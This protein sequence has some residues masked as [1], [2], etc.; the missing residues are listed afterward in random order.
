MA[1]DGWSDAIADRFAPTCCRIS[2]AALPHPAGNTDLSH[3]LAATSEGARRSQFLY[4]GL[5]RICPRARPAGW[6]LS[7]VGEARRRWDARGPIASAGPR[8]CSGLAI[9]AR[10]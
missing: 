10:V 4:G 9:K 6:I 3:D 5:H 1:T 2:K 7:T 8:V